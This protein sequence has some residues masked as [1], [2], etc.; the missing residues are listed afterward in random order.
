M[1]IGGSG[2]RG[3]GDFGFYNRSSAKRIFPIL[4][5]PKKSNNYEP[6]CRSIF[7]CDTK[8]IL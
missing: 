4:R 3:Y 1:T 8:G 5:E 6:V 2:I 7:I